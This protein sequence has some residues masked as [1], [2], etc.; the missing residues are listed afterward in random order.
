MGVGARGFII[1]PGEF[2]G[3]GE[4]DKEKSYENPNR[5]KHRRTD[6]STEEEDRAR[7]AQFVYA[8]TKLSAYARALLRLRPAT[9][10]NIGV[11]PDESLLRRDDDS[12][13]TWKRYL[14]GTNTQGAKGTRTTHKEVVLR[15]ALWALLDA[16]LSEDDI[17]K[18]G[19]EWLYVRGREPANLTMRARRRDGGG[20]RT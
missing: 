13:N 14:S 7:A 17:E 5:L 15:R 12:R 2:S 6:G 16:D 20:R 1:D 10:Q 11:L 9:P 3:S 8:K 18:L 4:W 19:R